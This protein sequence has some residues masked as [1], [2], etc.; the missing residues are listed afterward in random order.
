MSFAVTRLNLLEGGF[1]RAYSVAALQQPGL[2]EPCPDALQPASVLRMTS[3]R[4]AADAGVLQ[5]ERIV[6]Q[7]GGGGP[8]GGSARKQIAG[9]LASLATWVAR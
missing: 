8:M 9:G 1:A 3:H 7:T 6:G 5:H 4:F 2:R